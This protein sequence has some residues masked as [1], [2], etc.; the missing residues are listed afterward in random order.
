[1]ENKPTAGLFIWPFIPVVRLQFVMGI[2]CSIVLYRNSFHIVQFSASSSRRVCFNDGFDTMHVVCTD[3]LCVV[4]IRSLSAEFSTVSTGLGRPMF[5]V[6]V[7]Y[8]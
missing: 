8:S 1:M 4:C 6:A 7:E 5:S 2:N 3:L